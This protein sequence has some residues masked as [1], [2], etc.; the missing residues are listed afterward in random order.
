MCIAGCWGWVSF[1]QRVF[2]WNLCLE[3]FLA[4]SFYL[5]L[6]LYVFVTFSVYSYDVSFASVPRFYNFAT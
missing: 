4:L 6:S 1:N 5:A 2:W 3:K